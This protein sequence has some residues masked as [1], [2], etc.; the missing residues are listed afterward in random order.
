MRAHGS[1]RRHTE[2]TRALAHIGDT[3]DN[4]P[5]TDRRT[6]T[7]FSQ[8]NVINY[9]FI[10]SHYDNAIARSVPAGLRWRFGGILRLNGEARQRARA[11]ATIDG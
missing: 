2:H 4:Q 8:S 6:P 3:D 5:R 11:C 10:P 1:S 9:K 7:P